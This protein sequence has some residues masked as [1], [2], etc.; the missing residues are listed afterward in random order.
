MTARSI[1]LEGL[2]AP[3]LH[4]RGMEAESV[5]FQGAAVG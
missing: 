2:S 4:G 3:L 5:R 1:D